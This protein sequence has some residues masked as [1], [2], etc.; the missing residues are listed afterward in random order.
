LR[1]LREIPA[2]S[3]PVWFPTG[4][5]LGGLQPVAQVQIPLFGLLPGL[6]VPLEWQENRWQTKGIFESHQLT[7][8]K[9]EQVNL[10]HEGLSLNSL[11]P[12]YRFHSTDILLAE[13]AV[14]RT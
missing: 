14:G 7:R 11:T 2:I 3:A 13:A 9:I 4:K 5:V 1:L 6:P 12:R 10:Q 8:L